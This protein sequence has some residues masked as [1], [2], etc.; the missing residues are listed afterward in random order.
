MSAKTATLTVIIPCFNEEQVLPACY[1][2]VKSMLEGMRA[3]FGVEGFVLFVNDGSRDRTPFIL[4]DLAKKDPGTVQVIHLSRNFGHQ[5]ALTAGMRYCHTDFAV[6]MDADLQDPPEVIPEMYRRM[7][8]SE[9]DVV[10]GVR[11]ERQGETWFKKASAKA[12]YRI[13]NM[14]SEVPLPVDT[15][16]FR[17]MDKS[18]LDAFRSLPEHNKYIRGLISWLGFTQAPLEYRREARFAGKTKYSLSQMVSLAV[19]AMQHFSHKPLKLAMSLGYITVLLA[20]LLGLWVIL[21]KVFGFTHPEAG[22]SSIVF[23]IAFFAG[24]QL[25]SLGMLSSYVSL[26]FDEVKER[27]EYIVAR[28]LNL[29]DPVPP[30]SPL[31]LKDSDDAKREPR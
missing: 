31:T 23:F 11:S 7:R 18:V 29:P 13:L 15:G 6:S 4:N 27:P 12:F 25:I 30:F 8:D 28:T 16:D 21:G 26:I 20:V 22:W 9:V 17:M 10:Y 14:M 1:A 5:P 2:R 24:I 19:N 3:D